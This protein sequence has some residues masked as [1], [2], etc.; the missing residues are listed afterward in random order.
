MPSLLAI[1]RE[2]IDASV[3]EVAC[4]KGPHLIEL[5]FR[6]SMVLNVLAP[7]RTP[8]TDN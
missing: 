3:G 4:H 6:R 7:R 1:R 5:F 8:K 2:A